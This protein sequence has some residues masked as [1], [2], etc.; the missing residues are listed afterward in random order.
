MSR[1]VRVGVL[2]AGCMGSL[3]LVEFLV[4]ERADRSDIDVLV[5]GSGAKLGLKQ[6]ET[7]TAWMIAQKPDFTVLIGPAQQAPGPTKA[8]KLLAEAGVPT[9]VI[10]DGPAR[11]IASRLEADGFGYIIID[12][13]AMIGARR[14]FLDPVEMALFNAD[15]IKILAVTGVLRVITEALDDLIQAVKSG[16][17]LQLPRLLVTKES[18]VASSGLNNSYARAK[19]MAA[20]EIARRVAGV[21]SAACFKVPEWTRYVPLVASGHEM[22]RAA[23]KLADDAREMEKVGDTLVR[24]PHFPDGAVGVKTKLM[25]KP[26]RSEN[27]DSTYHA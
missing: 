14:E 21:D 15:M 8:R 16:S 19:A 9:V 20:Y 10:S 7:I 12:A 3:P 1:T 6:C 13:D 5:S 25:E 2:K 22:I 4:D 23:A 18:A 24:R 27:K 11:K 26:Q 17:G